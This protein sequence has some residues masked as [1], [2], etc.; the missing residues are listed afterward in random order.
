MRSKGTLAATLAITR[1][2]SASSFVSREAAN[3]AS[4]DGG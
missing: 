2:I 4:I 3:N 1:L